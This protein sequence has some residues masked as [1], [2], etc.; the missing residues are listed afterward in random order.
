MVNMYY[1]KKETKLGQEKSRKGQ[2]DLTRLSKEATQLSSSHDD[3][4]QLNS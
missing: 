3:S 4:V 2:I 1:L